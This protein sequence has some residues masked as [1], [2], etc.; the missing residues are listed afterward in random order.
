[1]SQV[2]HITPAHVIPV[3]ARSFNNNNYICTKMLVESCASKIQKYRIRGGR[4]I[5]LLA[6]NTH[7]E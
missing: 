4:I 2:L 7:D 1:M 6:S 3:N 5:R